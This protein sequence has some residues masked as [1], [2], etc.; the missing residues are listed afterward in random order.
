[1]FLK[2]L[3]KLITPDFLLQIYYDYK[4]KNKTFYGHHNLDQKLCEFLN[5][6]DGFFIELKQMMELDNLTHFTLKKF[7]LEWYI[8]R[9]Y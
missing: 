6:K 5:Y 3:V 8:N 2:K 1:M 4:N 7:K 9:T